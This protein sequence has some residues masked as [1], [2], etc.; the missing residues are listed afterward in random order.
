[1]STPDRMCAETVVDHLQVASAIP[2]VDFWIYL[3]QGGPGH[4]ELSWEGWTSPRDPVPITGDGVQD[5]RM[6]AD[7]LRVHLRLDV[8]PSDGG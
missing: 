7:L 3:T 4:V 8:N 5:G 2:C 1:L 6:L